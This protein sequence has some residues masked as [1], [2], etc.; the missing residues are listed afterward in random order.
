M[1]MDFEDPQRSIRAAEQVISQLT[2]ENVRLRLDI[3]KLIDYVSE[4][5]AELDKLNAEAEPQRPPQ[6]GPKPAKAKRGNEKGLTT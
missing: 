6:E 1:T 3:R 2:A 5:Q 4:M